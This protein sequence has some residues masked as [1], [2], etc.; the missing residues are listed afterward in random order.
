MNLLELTKEQ[1]KKI[2]PMFYFDEGDKEKKENRG[3]L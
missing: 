2:A 3:I 1:E